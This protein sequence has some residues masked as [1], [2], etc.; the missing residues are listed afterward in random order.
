MMLRDVF[1][2]PQEVQGELTGRK[3]IRAQGYQEGAFAVLDTLTSLNAPDPTRP[4]P[5]QD[6]GVSEDK[7]ER[8]EKGRAE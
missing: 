8:G 1:G 4:E 6:Y 3:A 2:R 7:S 5:I